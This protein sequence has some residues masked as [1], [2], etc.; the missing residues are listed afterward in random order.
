MFS[1]SFILFELR[2]LFE[3]LFMDYSVGKAGAE[4]HQA[5][6]RI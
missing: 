4:V 6:E 3:D 5:G 2:V 1:F